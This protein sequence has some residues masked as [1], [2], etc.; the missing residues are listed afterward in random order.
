MIKIAPLVARSWCL[1]VVIRAVVLVAELTVRASEAPVLPPDWKLPAVTNHP[2]LLFGAAESPAI[3]ARLIQEF[4]A[5]DKIGD[6]QLKVYFAGDEAARRQ[7]TADFISYWKGYS[8]RWGK[9]YQGHPADWIDGVSLRGVRRSLAIYDLVAS[10]GYLTD[11]QTREYRDALVSAVE[12]AIGSDYAHP[13]MTSNPKF[14][15]MNIWTDIVTAAGLIGLAFPEL[16]QSRSWIE[17]AVSEINWQLERGVWDGCWSESPRYHCAMLM[18]VGTFYQVLEQRTGVDLFSHPQYKALLDWPVRFETPLDKVAG[19]TL[20]HPEGVALLPGIGDSS[21]VA[22]SFGVPAMF[23]SH[24]VKSDPH[25][26][27]RLMWAWNRAGRPFDGDSVESAR[28]LIDPTIA[29]EPQKLGSDVS[30]GKGYVVMRSAVDTPGEIWFLLRC[31]KAT[32][33]PSHD[34]ADWNAFNIYAYGVPLALDSA[35]GAYSD[36]LHKAWHDKAVAHNTLVFGGR[37]Q[38]RKDGKI[39]TW[40]TRP[41]V[42]YSVSDASVP[43]GVE[44]FIRHVLFVKPSYF[45]IW[46]EVASSEPASWMLHTPAT[47]FE[48]SQHSVRCLTQWDAALDVQVVWP[49]TPLTPGTQQGKYSDWKENQKQRDPH[50]FQYQDYFGVTN[51]PGRDFLVVLHPCKPGEPALKVRDLGKPN[52][53]ALEIKQ[54]SQTDRIELRADGASVTLGHNAPL[55]LNNAQPA[56]SK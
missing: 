2:C 25:F 36:P 33:S 26:A 29:A 35:S 37:S 48:W 30:P 40:I 42:D 41:E 6:Q 55:W 19:S 46:D 27:A 18:I 14:H 39:L 17:L 47:K 11:E 31:G 4:G 32:L 52:R 56:S 45:V 44:K 49:K 8:Q 16:P 50:P 23:A 21:W 12:Y 54:G 13:R 3:K 22:N 5:L 1:L 43:A 51:A 28:V 7:A 9:T 24:Y 53:P 10:Y 34:N 15:M 20:G 38:E